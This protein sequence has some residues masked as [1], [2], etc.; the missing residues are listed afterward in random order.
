MINGLQIVAILPFFD[1]KSPG[2][3]NAF[4]K[5]VNDLASFDFFDFNQFTVSN[6]Y[7]PEVDSLPR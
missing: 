4:N 5:F 7:F 6:F 2:N 1:A 3:V